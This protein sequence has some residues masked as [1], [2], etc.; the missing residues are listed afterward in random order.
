MY[1]TFSAKTV[2]MHRH[3]TP[4]RVIASSRSTTPVPQHL[5]LAPP[6][7]LSRFR[8]MIPDS[9]MFSN[10]MAMVTSNDQPRVIDV[11]FDVNK[12]IVLHYDGHPPH[13]I[14]GTN[15]TPGDIDSLLE[16]SSVEEHVIRSTGR[17]GIHGT[18][19]RLSIL[20]DLDGSAS[21]LTLR[22][23]RH[24]PMHEV[25][26]DTLTPYIESGKSIL[27]F[28]HPGSGKTTLLRAISE[29]AG[30]V[31]SRRTTVV[32]ASGELGG[33]GTNVLGMFTR[34]MCT[35]PGHDMASTMLQAIRNHTPQ[36]LIVD[37]LVNIS[38]ASAAQTCSM[39]GIQLIAS[40]H[41]RDID[42]LLKNPIFRDKLFGGIQ[43]AAI[44]DTEA[45]MLGSK[46][47]KERKSDPVFDVAFDCSTR[48]V[49]ESLV[50][51]IDEHMS[52]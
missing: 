21:G 32:D 1:K 12:P 34:R 51:I 46:F 30:D 38:D 8:H 39:R 31:A 23:G 52:L 28:G 27:L 42:S 37:E 14:H 7:L 49:Y 33:T 26:P 24:V 17:A 20:Y 18:L 43:Q 40:V 5:P 41:A 15:V 19:H 22:V 16:A 35:P 4:R 44:G 9:D 13:K 2:S 29:Y 36:C 50:D 11:A 47:V 10:F 45:K 6:T 48:T 3:S 25:L